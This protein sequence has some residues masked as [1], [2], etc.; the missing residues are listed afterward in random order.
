[1][2]SDT[3]SDRGEF[4]ALRP[5]PGPIKF[6]GHFTRVLENTLDRVDAG[7]TGIES[8]LVHKTD[9]FVTMYDGYPKAALHLLVLPRQRLNSLA[10]LLP[11]HL[12][13]LRQLGAY[14]AWVM[15]GIAKARP[16]LQL[17]H[18]VHA[19]PSLHQLHV[20][21]VSQ[22][23]CSPSMKNAKHYNS[24]QPPF[25]VPLDDITMSLEDGTD[26][27][28]RFGLAH[29]KQRMEK[30]E[31]QCNRCGAEFH[32]SFAELKRHL[33]TCTAPYPAM[34]VPQRWCSSLTPLLG[35]AVDMRVGS[36]ILVGTSPAV[37]PHVAEA[38]EEED[39]EEIF[40]G[41]RAKFV[42]IV[43]LT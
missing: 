17:T 36:A 16:E 27:R 15:E 11:I 35:D 37:A 21:V 13:M 39:A 28:A 34:F 4:P 19:V 2:E 10:D 23:F 8:Y 32:R 30:R 41:K 31:L 33:A 5:S 3:A 9:E 22:D 29:A 40:R 14:V 12:P 42:D 18:G 38:I 25:L 6:A 7:D 1:M 24:F 43:D 20:H 26:V